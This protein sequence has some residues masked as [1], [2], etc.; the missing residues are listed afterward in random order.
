MT[1]P[2]AKPRG[3]VRSIGSAVLVALVLR[4]F[5]AEAYVIPSGSMV[6]TLEVGD[7]IE[8][9]KFAYG[10]G[11]PIAGAKFWLYDAPKP[12][13]VIVF[14]S[15]EDPRENLI[16]RVIGVPGDTIEIR[17]GVPVRN[18][19]ALSEVRVGVRTFHDFD[20][21]H[22]ERA[23]VRP[24]TE[25]RETLGDRTYSIYRMSS[26]GNGCPPQATWGCTGPFIVPA[27]MVYVLGD[28]RDDSND[29]RFWG[30]VPMASIRGRAD[31]VWW[32]RDP[33]RTL[34]LGV[35][36]ERLGQRIR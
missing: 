34:P 4:S 25:F 17:D 20:L 5:V 1:G 18:G 19:H 7:H 22:P 8:V 29:S 2:K 32:S 27:G 21:E 14:E 26:R 28:N 36:T 23:S 35:R 12:G 11:W 3:L 15:R 10:V 24:A 9:T 31:F 6:P 16:K 13:E 33:A 30:V